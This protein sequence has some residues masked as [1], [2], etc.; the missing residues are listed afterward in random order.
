MCKES[1]AFIYHHSS[2]SWPVHSSR[3]TYFLYITLLHSFITAHAVDTITRTLV[4]YKTTTN[5]HRLQSASLKCKTSKI[6]PHNLLKPSNYCR[7]TVLDV[8]VLLFPSHGCESSG[9]SVR[10]GPNDLQGSVAGEANQVSKED[11]VY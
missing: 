8:F 3:S 1:F 2:Y 5:Y 4:Q 10:C 11:T 6:E 7:A 9:F